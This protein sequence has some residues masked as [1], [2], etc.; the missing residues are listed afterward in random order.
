MILV[1]DVGG[2][3]TL[4]ALYCKKTKGWILYKERSYKSAVF[5][6]IEAIIRVFLEDEKHSIQAVCAG[7]AGTI[8][9]KKCQITNLTWSISAEEIQK[10]TG[11]KKVYLLNDLAAT[12]WAVALADMRYEEINVKATAKKVAG[13]VAILSAGTGLG[14]AVLLRDHLGSYKVLATEGGHVSFAPQNE[15]QDRLL[16]FLREKYKG[17]VSYER[18]VSG[19]GVYN[20]YLFLQN[21]GRFFVDNKIIKKIESNDP[22]EVISLEA[23]LGSDKLCKETLRLF[24]EIYAAEAGN[25]ALKCLPQG[26]VVL[27]GGISP[28]ILNLIKQQFMGAFKNKGRYSTYLAELPIRVCLN[29]NAVL[30]GALAYAKAQEK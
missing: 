30:L 21:E 29:Q 13:N 12:A 3:K 22:A 18:L 9:E 26:G 17:H 5:N 23:T 8:V 1:I 16:I 4:L 11:A 14:E 28:K 20:I 10:I 6:S 19:S 24:C 2:T 7:V 25:L 27:A 15:E